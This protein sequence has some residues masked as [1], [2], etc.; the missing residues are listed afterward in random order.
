MRTV[1][2]TFFKMFLFG[3]WRSWQP[4][5]GSLR[6]LFCVCECHCLSVP[7]VE[8]SLLDWS[9]LLAF[10][11]LRGL[12]GPICWLLNAQ[13]VLINCKHLSPLFSTNNQQLWQFYFGWIH[14]VVSGLYF[15][16]FAFIKSMGFSRAT[17]DISWLSWRW[18]ESQTTSETI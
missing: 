16:W 18:P 9:W 10:L 2:G 13:Q 6:F 14:L 4:Y 5:L 1:D 15:V 11:N 12:S 7:K 17:A 3:K 8:E